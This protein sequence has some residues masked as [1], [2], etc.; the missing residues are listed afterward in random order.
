MATVIQCKK[1]ECRKDCPILPNMHK[2][3]V[4]GLV[5]LRKKCIGYIYKKGER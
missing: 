5:T 1:C 4:K 2:K 3:G